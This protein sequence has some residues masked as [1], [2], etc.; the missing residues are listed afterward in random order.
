MAETARGHHLSNAISTTAKLPIA[1]TKYLASEPLIT[2]PLL[3][4]LTRGPVHL[5]QRL[6]DLPPVKALLARSGSERLA[7]AIKVL[8]ALFVIGAIDRVNRALTSLALNGWKLP[9][10]EGRARWVWDGKTEIVVITGGCS[11]F[12]YEMV[13]GFAGKAKVIVLDV[14][15]LPAE[16]EKCEFGTFD[17]DGKGCRLTCAY[18]RSCRC[19]PELYANSCYSA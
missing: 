1:L 4:I 12:G 19:S 10:T 14:Q 8:K 2:G 5:R 15:D 11:G 7:T 16:L 6:L 18:A 9:G 17:F 3:Y 13:K